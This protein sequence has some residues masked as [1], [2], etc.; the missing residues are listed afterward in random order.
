MHY[1]TECRTVE[2]KFRS[3]TLQEFIDVVGSDEG[4]VEDSD[5]DDDRVCVECDSV[6]SRQSVPDH[7]WNEER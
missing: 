3:L 4:F 6:G 2:G 1:C 5:S 7:D